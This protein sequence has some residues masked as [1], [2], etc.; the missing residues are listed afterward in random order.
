MK[1]RALGTLGED[2]GLGVNQDQV[3]HAPRYSWPGQVA[4][5]I[6]SD[7][8]DQDIRTFYNF[9]KITL[10]RWN[11]GIMD[12]HQGPLEQEACDQTLGAFIA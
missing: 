9:V 6:M 10:I 8:D 2:A 3:M 4:V 12:A 5:G 7:Q 11:P 1:S